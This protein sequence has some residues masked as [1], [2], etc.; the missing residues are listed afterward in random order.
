MHVRVW[1]RW[2]VRKYL[3]S[4]INP[5]IGYLGISIILSYVS[6]SVLLYCLRCDRNSHYL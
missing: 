4:G 3:V 6:F 5:I 2:Q 1:K